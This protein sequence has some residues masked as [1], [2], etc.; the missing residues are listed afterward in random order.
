MT[1]EQA[2]AAQ[3]GAQLL[4]T[5]INAMAQSNINKKTQKW[6]E[7]IMAQQRQQSL[8]DWTMQNEYNSPKAQMQRLKMA[9]LNPNLV[10]G[11]GADNIASPIRST[12][13]K[14]WNPQAPQVDL[15]MAST[16]GQYLNFKTQKVQTDNLL[17]QN[18]VIRQQ[19]KLTAAQTLKLL[20]DIDISKFDLQQ[21]KQLAPLLLDGQKKQIELLSADLDLKRAT[22]QKTFTDTEN[23]IWQNAISFSQG[24]ENIIQS[25]LNQAK[26]KEETKNLME[27]RRNLQADRTLKDFEILLNKTGNTKNDPIIMRMGAKFLEELIGKV[28]DF[29]IG[30]FLTDLFSGKGGTE[31][32]SIY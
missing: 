26:T 14:S 29:S 3:A 5:G 11:K 32:G 22:T 31:T 27:A 7:K 21:K 2:M 12:D 8:A 9:G 23:S 25:R 16:L 4:G 18:E 19:E 24:L 28:K 20:T 10:Y 17:A 6:N 13:V 30:K 15:N 1:E